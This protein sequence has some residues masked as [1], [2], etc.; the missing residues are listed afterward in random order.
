MDHRTRQRVRAHRRR[1]AFARALHQIGFVM[2]RAYGRAGRRQNYVGFSI[3]RKSGLRQHR[4]HL[5]M[6]FRYGI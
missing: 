3:P 6:A 4:K 1:K 2:G 5:Y